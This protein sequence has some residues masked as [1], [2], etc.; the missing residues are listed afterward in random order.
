V[1][2]RNPADGSQGFG[3]ILSEIDSVEVPAAA[4]IAG[5]WR[6]IGAFVFD[7]V[8]LAL[9]A[10]V[11]WWIWPAQV[12]ALGSTGR[13]VGFGVA[14]LYFGLF[15]SRLCNGQTPGKIL[16]RIRVVGADGQPIT[17][18]R[19]LVRQVVLGLPFYMNGAWL[20]AVFENTLALM[21]AA[22]LVVF[23]GLFAIY[24]L[25][26]FNRR[27]RQSL[28]DLAVR[29][30]VVD[31]EPEAAALAAP[32]LWRGH[33]IP[34]GLVA[35]AALV[36]PVFLAPLAKT[37]PFVDMSATAQ[38]LMT[39]PEVRGAKVMLRT[40]WN[41]GQ[42]SSKQLVAVVQVA[43]PIHLNEAVARRVAERVASSYPDAA[44]YPTRV[45]QMHWGFDLG[46][47]S[48]SQQQT[49]LLAGLAATGEAGTP[50]AEP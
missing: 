46:V 6:R 47:L 45:V 21:M 9:L 8:V 44:S 39:E 42:G 37:Q 17:V 22:T 23:G 15:N 11:V 41:T 33:W 4:H 29:T 31:E 49:F 10:G 28:H 26:L 5:F 32:P 1:A 40:A 24:Y 25:Y 20:P 34:V 12:V 43:E 38:A 50:S 14:L 18:P 13:W 35:L 48:W 7:T 27:S 3:G 36:A 19:A 2:R 16:L 30:W